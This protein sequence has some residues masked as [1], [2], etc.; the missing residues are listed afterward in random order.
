MFVFRE[1]CAVVLASR[2]L[3]QPVKWIEDRR[4]NLLSA[5]HSRN[6]LGKVRMAVDDDGV[7][8]AITVEH[9]ADV[10]AYPACPAAMDPALLVGPVQDPA[11]RLLACR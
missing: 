8:Q 4:E 10:G 3:G 6:E 5:P 1:E 7:I 9:K 2:M 11:P